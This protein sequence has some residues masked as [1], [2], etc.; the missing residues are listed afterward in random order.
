MHNRKSI[1]LCQVCLIVGFQVL[2]NNHSNCPILTN[3]AK[4]VW[5]SKSRNI[6][7]CKH[8]YCTYWVM[9]TSPMPRT[10]ELTSTSPDGGQDV[11]SWVKTI[12]LLST[13]PDGGQEVSSQGQDHKAP[14]DDGQDVPSPVKTTELTSTSLQMVD[15]ACPLRS[16]PQ[17]SRARLSR[18]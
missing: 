9:I 8:Q 4:N 3:F 15:M 12:E 13:S 7:K 18:W 11:A 6:L 2:K 10:I 17:S 1:C 14:P 16:K 5:V